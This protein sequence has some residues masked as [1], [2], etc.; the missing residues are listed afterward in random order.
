MIQKYHPKAIVGV[1]CMMEIKEGIDLCYRYDISAIGV[2]LLEAG[3][4][5]TTLDWD[6]FYEIISDNESYAFTETDGE[7]ALKVNK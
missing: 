6:K 2:P 7:I 5:C 4:V 3:C 1:G